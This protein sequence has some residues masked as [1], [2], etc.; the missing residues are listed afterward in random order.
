MK[1]WAM[2]PLFCASRWEHEQ[3]TGDKLPVCFDAREYPGAAYHVP[4][5]LT[6]TKNTPRARFACRVALCTL[7]A[8]IIAWASSPTD[9]AY[10]HASH[11]C[12][13]SSVL[14]FTSQRVLPLLTVSS[15]AHTP[16]VLGM[17]LVTLIDRGGEDH[18]FGITAVEAG[19][20]QRFCDLLKQCLVLCKVSYHTASLLLVLVLSVLPGCPRI[21]HMIVCAIRVD[22]ACPVCSLAAIL[23]RMVRVSLIREYRSVG[24]GPLPVPAE[25][26]PR[27]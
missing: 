10:R 11:V 27:K 17:E 3:W 9:R 2:P 15:V 14:G 6:L 12:F 16:S 19:F 21:D 5:A 20:P 24:F 18:S 26:A 13:H 22:L 23:L 1:K 4:A 25:N 8:R 7:P